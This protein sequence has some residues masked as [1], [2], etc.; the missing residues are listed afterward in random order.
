[1]DV[2]P[3]VILHVPHDSTVIPDEVRHQFVAGDAELAAELVRMTDHHTLDLLALAVPA[4]QIVRAPVSRLVVD[5]ERF[6]D[7]S[8]EPMSACGMG[9][10]YERMSDGRPLR[11]P[12]SA[13]ERQALID[14]WYRPHHER[15]AAAVQR[16]ID[17]HGEAILVDLHSF[18]SRPLPYEADQRADRPGICIGTDVFH[19]P[20]SLEAAFVAAFRAG[21]FDVRLNAPFAG[22][23][24]PVSHY[25]IDRHVSAVMIEVNRALYA[26][27]SSGEKNLGFDELAAAIRRCIGDALGA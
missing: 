21:G 10:V 5:V 18:P 11:R 12:I 15:L 25:R 4:G 26:Q 22:A 13:P 14:A 27:E 3:W 1:M 7:D 23:L 8:A 24:V 16:A 17:L 19:T 6:E 2:P 9:V 20:A